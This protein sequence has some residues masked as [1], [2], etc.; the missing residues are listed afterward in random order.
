SLMLTGYYSANDVKQN[1]T[2]RPFYQAWDFSFFDVDE[3]L[4]SGRSFYN[5]L[6]KNSINSTTLDII[7]QLNLK[8]FI[9]LRNSTLVETGM[10]D[11]IESPF[12]QDID[13]IATL[14]L[15]TEHY[16]LWEF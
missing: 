3:S 12:V 9:T 4:Q 5:D 8:Y 10:T 1:T 2:F 6:V 13:T 14:I 15:E 11:F 7:S 16:S